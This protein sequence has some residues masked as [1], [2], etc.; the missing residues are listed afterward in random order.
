MG[1]TTVKD[2]VIRR[3]ARRIYPRID[4]KADDLVMR[5]QDGGAFVQGWVWVPAEEIENEEK[6]IE[7]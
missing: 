2:P 3:A 7:S 1:R 4:V 6:E 5:T